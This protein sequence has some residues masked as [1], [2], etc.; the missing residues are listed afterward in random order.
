MTAAGPA[1]LILTAALD[2]ASS[3][4]FERERRQHFPAD[5]NIVPAHVTLFH[6]LPGDQ[7]EAIDACLGALAGSQPVAGFAIA[8]VRFLG[9]GSAYALD[10][11]AV[12]ALRQELAKRWE[13]WLTPQDRQR[14]MPHVTVQ[15]KAP[16]AE[17]KRLH[18]SLLA[19][20]APHDGTVLGLDL[21]H[22]L[23]GPW[24]QAGHYPFHPVRAP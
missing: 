19:G 20:F 18:A 17:A 1:P 24:E 10:M 15:N 12:S 13:P 14:W 3:A 11:P 6:H 22:Y 8:S 9:R 2:P 4:R 21:W 7:V 5:R 23:N 16:P